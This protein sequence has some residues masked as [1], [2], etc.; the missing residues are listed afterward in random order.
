LKTASWRP[1]HL[2]LI[3]KAGRREVAHWCR[4]W[5]SHL[6]EWI[7]WG[8]KRVWVWYRIATERTVW[9]LSFLS[10]AL[11]ACI[12]FGFSCLDI[13][14]AL[15]FWDELLNDVDLEVM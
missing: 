12:S 5:T 15:E 11:G 4:P 14:F 3:L 13:A 9:V 1:V 2:V 8:L 6:R 10:T 7:R